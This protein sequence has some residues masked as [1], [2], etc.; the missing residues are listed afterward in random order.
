MG[1]VIK[2]YLGFFF[3]LLETILGIGVISA[4]VDTVSAQNYHADVITE[5]EA[6]NF[7]PG[8]I[9]AC[10]TQAQAEGYHLIITPMEYDTQN[11][12]QIAEVIMKYN[13]TIRAISLSSEHQ[14]RGFAR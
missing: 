3:L 10:K 6:S 13:Y 4:G 9:T 8:V 11:N 14:I 2:S 12:I 7:N 5:I 1:Q